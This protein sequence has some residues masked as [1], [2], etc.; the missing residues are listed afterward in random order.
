MIW[1]AFLFLVAKEN[2]GKSGN[3]PHFFFQFNVEVAFFKHYFLA[4]LASCVSAV[5]Y[6]VSCRHFSLES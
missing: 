3:V 4:T 1:L 6:C 2:S 5:T